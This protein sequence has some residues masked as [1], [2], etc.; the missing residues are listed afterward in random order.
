[1]LQ[2]PGYQ[3]NNQE[4]LE[5]TKKVTLPELISYV[6]SVWS[7]GKGIALVQGNVDE[8]QAK[9]LVSTIDKALAFEP[10]SATEIPAELVP[11][12]IPE[13]SAGS[14]GTRLVISGM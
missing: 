6:G 8:N 1:M 9:A 11:L 14:M 7:S 5:A 2:P 13:S 4:L 12:P 10:I 3:Y